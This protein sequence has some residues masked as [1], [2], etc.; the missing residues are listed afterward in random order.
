HAPNVHNSRRSSVWDLELGIYLGFGIWCWVF[1]CFC[2]DMQ[3]L[4]LN[5]AE[6]GQIRFATRFAQDNQSQFPGMVVAPHRAF[7]IGNLL[8]FGN[9]VPAL[10]PMVKRMKQ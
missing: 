10:G 6:E 8:P 3:P 7:A 5:V 9:V 2:G 4:K 1:G